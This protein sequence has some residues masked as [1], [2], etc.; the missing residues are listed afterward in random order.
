MKNVS[1]RELGQVPDE[2]LTLKN[3][4]GK[5]SPEGVL[6]ATSVG[7][8]KWVVLKFGGTSVS[9]ANTWAQIVQR[10]KELQ[11]E[12]FRVMLV[13]SALSQVTN[14]LEMCLK[15]AVAHQELV[16]LQFIEDTHRRLAKEVGLDSSCLKEVLEKINELAQL[17]EGVGMIG[18]VSPRLQARICSYGEHMSTIMAVQILK[19]SGIHGSLFMSG[20]LIT[21]SMP[22]NAN[23][24][25]KYLNANVF[26]RC[27]PDWAEDVLE[28]KCGVAEVM[29]T[30][31]FVAKN[32]KVS[33]LLCARCSM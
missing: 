8:R 25:D 18:E 5:D 6:R 15:E 22:L 26:P 24:T 11:A 4:D 12:G 19:H 9:Y 33:V 31:G 7:R 16:S 1:P 17:L 21:T 3:T 23:D 30:Q 27:E 20:D 14:R 10:V 29:V 32:P 28:S 13:L 2:M